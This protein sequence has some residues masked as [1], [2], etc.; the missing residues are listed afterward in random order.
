MVQYLSIYNFIIWIYVWV[1]ILEIFNEI[2]NSFW[3]LDFLFQ[4]S[5]KKQSGYISIEINI[6]LIT[7]IGSKLTLRP[8]MLK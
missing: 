1:Y 2:I 5:F 3:F 7:N 4:V 6:N 8:T